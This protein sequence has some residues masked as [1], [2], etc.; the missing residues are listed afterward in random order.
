MSK[1]PT[2][3]ELV[4]TP[5][6]VLTGTS[7]LR[8]LGWTRT[9]IDAIWRACPVVVLPGTRWPVLRVEDYLAYLEQHN[10]PQR[11]AAC[12]PAVSAARRAP[13]DRPRTSSAS[14]PL[15]V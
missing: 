7:D 8:D 15:I 10:L 9:H 14:A 4:N 2:A 6:A 13:A 1:K 12:T 5:G 3:A 11:A